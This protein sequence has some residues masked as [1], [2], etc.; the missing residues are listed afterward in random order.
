MFMTLSFSGAPDSPRRRCAEEVAFDF[1]ARILVDTNA[2]WNWK[3][4]VRHW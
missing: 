2:S 1:M 4:A 3:E